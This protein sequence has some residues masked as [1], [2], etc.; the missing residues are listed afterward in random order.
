MLNYFQNV[1]VCDAR[2][3]QPE[4]CRWLHKTV[5]CIF[6]FAQIL[7]IHNNYRFHFLAGRLNNAGAKT[8]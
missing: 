7:T 1:Q 2:D 5:F 8:M 3:D 6:G 4:R